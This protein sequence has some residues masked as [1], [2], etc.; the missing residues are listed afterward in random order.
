MVQ[1]NQA[2]SSDVK[3]ARSEE[4]WLRR[5]YLDEFRERLE[6]EYDSVGYGKTMRLEDIKKEYRK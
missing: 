2:S 1:H 3:G 4:H 6:K 5:V